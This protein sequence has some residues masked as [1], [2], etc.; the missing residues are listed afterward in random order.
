M[1]ALLVTLDVS[2]R[3]LG[4]A[5]LSILPFVLLYEGAR[6]WS[7]SREWRNARGWLA[8]GLFLVAIGVGMNAVA[9]NL[10]EKTLAIAAPRPIPTVDDTW[11]REF[12]P[13]KREEVSRMLAMIALRESLEVRSFVDIAGA[14][15]PYCATETDL[16]EIQDTASL[17]A[18]LKEVMDMNKRTIGKLL[19]WAMV[20][21]V[22]GWLVGH[23]LRKKA[24]K[25]AL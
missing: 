24:Q 21:S 1:D 11:G 25:S 14:W 9:V 3:T 5:I 10:S 2:A 7:F 15:K 8:G 23:E 6:Q 20:A 16:K 4:N 19:L 22:T 13:A 17:K 12:T 18:T